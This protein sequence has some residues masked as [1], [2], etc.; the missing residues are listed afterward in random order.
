[1]ANTH[2][3]G[4]VYDAKAADRCPSLLYVEKP[5]KTHGKKPL[6]QFYAYCTANGRC[7]CLGNIASFTG[8]SPT[9]CPRRK[10]LEQHE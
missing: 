9:W 10:E 5:G 2:L 6:K 4:S 8:N 1:M 7:R 3:C